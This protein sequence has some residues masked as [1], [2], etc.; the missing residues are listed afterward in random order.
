M[1]SQGTSKHKTTKKA[2]DA[3]YENIYVCYFVV[4]MGYG[5][6]PRCQY[7]YIP[8]CNSYAIHV[9]LLLLQQTN[10][11][12]S[13]FWVKWAL[14]YLQIVENS[15][16]FNSH[17]FECCTVKYMR[18]MHRTHRHTPHI[19]IHMGTWLYGL[20]NAIQ[21]SF[22]SLIFFSLTAITWFLYI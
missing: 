4:P 9:R 8:N 19:A 22:D 16:K 18:N 12:K 11:I 6:G 10:Q 17:A 14:C 5:W 7:K 15:C 13:R 2:C 3:P 1:S 21:P 20:E